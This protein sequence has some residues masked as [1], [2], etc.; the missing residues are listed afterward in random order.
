MCSAPVTTGG[1]TKEKYGYQGTNVSGKTASFAPLSAASSTAASTFDTVP[2]EVSR[3]GAI[4]TAATR[5]NALSAI[6]SSSASVRRKATSDRPDSNRPDS[7]RPRVDHEGVVATVEQ[8]EIE[9][10]ERIDR[11]DAGD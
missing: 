3:S 4:C 7:N 9:H 8:D 5:I 6:S 11:P 2:P 1:W 10:I